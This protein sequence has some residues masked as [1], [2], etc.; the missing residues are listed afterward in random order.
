MYQHVFQKSTR[1]TLARPDVV[2]FANTS[3]RA[4]YP[5]RILHRHTDRC[6][7]ILV[8]GGTGEFLIGSRV[9]PV[10]KGDLV[11]LNAGDI[12]DERPSG[13]LA[14]ETFCCGIAGILQEDLPANHICSEG[15]IPVIRTH[16]HY[17]FFYHIFSYMNEAILSGGNAARDLCTSLMDAAVAMVRQL[18]LSQ[19]T[20]FPL[21]SESLMVDRIR[22]F[23]DDH[24][25]EVAGLDEIADSM[26]VS[27]SYLSH[28]FK[29]ET[30]YSPKQ[31]VILRRLGEAQ[32][33]L[34]LSQTPVTEIAATIGYD[35]SNYFSTLFT[36]T[37]NMTPSKYRSF[38][39]ADMFSDQKKK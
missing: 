5:P 37:V 39:Q 34:A 9:Y 20:I 24:Y 14:F 36:K 29:R 4:F 21:D 1:P 35:N 23:L 31:Y 10:A 22:T 7:I 38:C 8:T 32:T 6:E 16:Q 27:I 11:L 12:H 18:L 30:G 28:V 15:I 17:D 2:Y 13:E 25:N 26:N 19:E 33:L 3:S